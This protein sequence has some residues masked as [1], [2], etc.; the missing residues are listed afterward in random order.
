MHGKIIVTTSVFWNIILLYDCSR[1]RGVVL[2][3]SVCL[4]SSY[5]RLSTNNAE[6]DTV[7]KYLEKSWFLYA[8]KASVMFIGEKWQPWRKNT[9]IIISTVMKWLTCLISAINCRGYTGTFVCFAICNKILNNKTLLIQ[10]RFVFVTFIWQK[11]IS[12]G[13]GENGRPCI[14]P[15][16]PK[17]SVVI[18]MTFT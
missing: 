4:D 5:L 15:Y 6:T 9:D 8:V 17:D 18:Y 11:C 3:T 13:Y 16:L 14:M 12:K 1:K 2:T 10:D 7:Y